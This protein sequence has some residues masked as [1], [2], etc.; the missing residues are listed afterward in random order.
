MSR[1]RFFFIFD[2]ECEVYVSLK[3][4]MVCEPKCDSR[5]YVNDLQFQCIWCATHNLIVERRAHLEYLI[6]EN[7][8]V[9]AVCKSKHVVFV[10]SHTE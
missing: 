10:D 6:D 4:L 7:A 3:V 9:S 2:G 1:L 8:W 5:H